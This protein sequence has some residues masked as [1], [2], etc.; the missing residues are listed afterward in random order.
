MNRN[1]ASVALT[2]R[3]GQLDW[4]P[5]YLDLCALADDVLLDIL[6]WGA[7]RLGYGLL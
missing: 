5:K 1:G 3:A 7:D 6:K 4:L 2:N